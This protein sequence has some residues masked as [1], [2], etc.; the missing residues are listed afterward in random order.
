MNLMNNMLK[1]ASLLCMILLFAC[2]DEPEADSDATGGDDTP[3]I[4]TV[5]EARFKELA[6][7]H[8]WTTYS[9]D[10]KPLYDNLFV[11]ESGE[12]E[13]CGLTGG[14]PLYCRAF[15]L[16]GDDFY[17]FIRYGFGWDESMGPQFQSVPSKYHFDEKS[18]CIISDTHIVNDS[19]TAEDNII[20]VESLTKDIMV[21]R[22]CFGILRK[23]H[24]TDEVSDEPDPNS[25]MRVTYKRV[26]T[27]EE[28]KWWE[29]YPTYKKS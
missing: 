27:E 9:I 8:I 22:Q 18:G 1:C 14:S 6:D 26:P 7:G 21:T 28:A 2:S 20:Y 19:F 16:T 4:A 11:N 13:D 15:N 5:S 23:G 10:D 25:Y 29:H 12:Y 17:S 24:E 3:T